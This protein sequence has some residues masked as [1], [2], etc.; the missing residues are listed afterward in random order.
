VNTLPSESELDEA[1]ERGAEFLGDLPA[2][3]RAATD[4]LRNAL[5]RLLLEDVRT[6]DDYVV[7]SKP[8]LSVALFSNLVCQARRLSGR[9]DES[10]SHDGSLPPGAVVVALLTPPRTVGSSGHLAYQQPPP[11]QDTIR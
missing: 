3:W 2:A 10:S 9:S 11:S 7:T 8:Q 4:E 5:A 6:K 1:L